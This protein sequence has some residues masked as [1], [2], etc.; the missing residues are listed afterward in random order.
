MTE[1]RMDTRVEGRLAESRTGWV[2]WV[3]FA[4]IMMMVIG[5]LQAIYGLVAIFNDEWVVWG[6]G[7]AVLL[8]ITAWG[9]IHLAIG[10]LVAL[11]GIGVLSG[12]ALARAV[13][14]V[15]AAVSLL[16]SFA[17]LPLYPVWSL[18]VIGLDVLVIWALVAH[19]SELRH[20]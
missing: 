13:G 3:M 2:G 1:T 10:V 17:A 5:G 12:N 4:G 6:N 19:G 7:N 8:D 14:V 9:W 16:A 18:V 20:V 15:V 11:A